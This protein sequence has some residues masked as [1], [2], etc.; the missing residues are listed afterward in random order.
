M[1][2]QATWRKRG[3]EYVNVLWKDGRDNGSITNVDIA[4]LERVDENV[5]ELVSN[6][7]NSDDENSDNEEEEGDDEVFFEAK[8]DFYEA[9]PPTA[10][11]GSQPTSAVTPK[12]TR[13]W[14]HWPATY[15]AFLLRPHR[16][17]ACSV[18]RA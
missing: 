4:T 5:P 7:E 2:E 10:T 17:N 16:L 9:T 15:Y 6:D 8:E 3:R 11:S 14:R 13:V 12:R 18:M 1:L